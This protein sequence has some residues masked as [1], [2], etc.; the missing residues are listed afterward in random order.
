MHHAPLTNMS[1][2]LELIMELQNLPA[3]LP[4][5]G[6][7]FGRS[8]IGKSEAAEFAGGQVDAVF[9]RATST[10]T[11]KWF[12]EQ[13]L[14]ELGQPRPRGTLAHMTD[15]AANRLADSGRPVI[16]DEADHVVKKRFIE[17]IRD[18]HDKSKAPFLLIGEEYLADHLAQWERFHNRM[19]FMPASPPTDRDVLTLRDFY[20]RAD[21]HIADDLALHFASR[22]K[23]S[24]RRI[25]MN[26]HQATETALREGWDSVDLARWGN[27]PVMTGQV[28][29]AN[30][31]MS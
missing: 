5:M 16:L 22:V 23:G 25:A 17:L 19:T 31:Q 2:C 10:A 13:L 26:L 28:D 4:R 6:G 20:K 27:R 3:Y 30:R 14:I 12:L 21:V 15:E 29:H 9:V 11:P 24:I 18:L 1:L 7:F 8:G